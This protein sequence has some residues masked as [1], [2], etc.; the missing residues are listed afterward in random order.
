[1]NQRQKL[2]KKYNL[3]RKSIQIYYYGRL[4]ERCAEKA[5]QFLQHTQNANL[6]TNSCFAQDSSHTRHVR[7]VPLAF[8]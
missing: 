6:A 5:I 8:V 4:F 2:P 1:M 7:R 3:R